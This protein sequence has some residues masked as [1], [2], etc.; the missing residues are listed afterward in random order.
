MPGGCFDLSYLCACAGLP[1]AIALGGLKLRLRAGAAK[2]CVQKSHDARHGFRRLKVTPA[3][4]AT[5]QNV[6]FK[7]G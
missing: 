6:E 7:P 1:R 3:V 5:W 2:L 4:G